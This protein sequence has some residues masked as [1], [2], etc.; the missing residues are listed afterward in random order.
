M[1]SQREA[2]PVVS[3]MD[4]KSVHIHSYFVCMKDD[5]IFTVTEA[6]IRSANTYLKDFNVDI[7]LLERSV[8]IMKSF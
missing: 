1:F 5:G 7:R 4:W 8:F 2:K 6:F 3:N